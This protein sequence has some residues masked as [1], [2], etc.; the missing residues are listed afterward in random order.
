[1]KIHP[2]ADCIERAFGSSNGFPYVD[3]YKSFVDKDGNML[4]Q[5]FV[6]LVHPTLAGYKIMESICLPI[7]NA[8]IGK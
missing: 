2:E 5:Y 3:Y 1:M 4:T 6:D 7:I 8:S